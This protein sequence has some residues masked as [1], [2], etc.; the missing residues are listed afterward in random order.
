MSKFVLTLFKKFDSMTSRGEGFDQGVGENPAAP[1]FIALFL[2]RTHSDEEEKQGEMTFFRTHSTPFLWM[3][4][5]SQ[6]DGKL[7]H[8]RAQY[9]EI[10]Q[11]VNRKS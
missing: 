10:S 2:G 1:F 5:V 7:R 8:V 9:A 6:Q 11:I 3:K 4:E